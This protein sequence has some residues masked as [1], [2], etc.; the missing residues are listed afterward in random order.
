[1]RQWLVLLR[2]SSVRSAREREKVRRVSKKETDRLRQREREADWKGGRN[3]R[4]KAWQLRVRGSVCRDDGEG[5]RRRRRSL[6]RI[7]HAR[8]GVWAAVAAVAA[9]GAWRRWS[10]LRSMEASGCV[11]LGA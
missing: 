9:S 2:C 11:C 4:F 7:I 8:G 3:T 1:M 6:F 10:L 5:R